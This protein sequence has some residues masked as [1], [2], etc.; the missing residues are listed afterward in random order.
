MRLHITLEDG[1]VADLDRRVGQRGRS[2][3]I[4]G[5]IRQALDDAHRWEMLEAAIGSIDDTGHEWDD[6]PAGWV[7]RSRRADERRVG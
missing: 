1:L 3:F 4:A 5:A 7:H 2:R 6:D